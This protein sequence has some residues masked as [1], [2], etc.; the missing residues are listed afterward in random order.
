MV[1]NRM[2]FCVWDQILIFHLELSRVLLGVRS[3][4]HTYVK[5]ENQLTSDTGIRHIYL[6]LLLTSSRSFS[7][8]LFPC[9]HSFMYRVVQKGW[10]HLFPMPQENRRW[11]LHKIKGTCALFHGNLF[12][13]HLNTASSVLLQSGDNKTKYLFFTCSQF[14]QNVTMGCRL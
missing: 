8:F 14:C 5:V 4:L 9:I 13:M 1:D 12:G 3:N 2:F 7:T 10:K 11:D 6:S